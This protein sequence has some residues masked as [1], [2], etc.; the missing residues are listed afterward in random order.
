M[1][2]IR[3]PYV[4]GN[5]IYHERGSGATTGNCSTNALLKQPKNSLWVTWWVLVGCGT[6]V[7]DSHEPLIVAT[8]AEIALAA[9]SSCDCEISFGEGQSGAK[10]TIAGDHDTLCG[11]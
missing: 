5:G 9:I 10:C 3:L 7:L 6:H 4:V 8:T 1:H 11:N 2:D